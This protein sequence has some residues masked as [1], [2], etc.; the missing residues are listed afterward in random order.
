[1]PEEVDY[2]ESC[3]LGT[4]GQEAMTTSRGEIRVDARRKPFAG[5]QGCH[6]GVLRAEFHQVDG[7]ASWLL[8]T[9]F[10]FEMETRRQMSLQQ[11]RRSEVPYWGNASLKLPHNHLPEG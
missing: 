3:S 7:D 11:S 6:R 8:L 4:R 10:R 1:M 9:K 5:S 2:Y